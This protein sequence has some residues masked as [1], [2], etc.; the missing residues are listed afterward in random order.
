[1]ANDA[2]GLERIS[3]VVGY[4]L[5]KGNF[6]E[7]TPNLPQRIAILAEANTANQGSLDLTPKELTSAQAAGELYG[8][9]S[10]IYNIMRILRPNQGVGVG[11]IPTVVYPQAV[12][13]G[14]VANETEVTPVGTATKNGTHTLKI[15][16]RNG[17]DG[18]FYDINIVVG[19][20][21]A[22]VSTKIAD[23]IQAV[24]S[25]PCN[26]V[27]TA[28]EATLTAK[29]AG[30]T[31]EEMVVSVD[32]NDTDLGIT[33]VVAVTD[34]GL[35]TPSIAAA[36][37]LFGN[38]WNTVVINSYGTVSAAIDTLE[39]FNGIPDPLVP[40]GRYVGIV[41]KPFI[42]FTGSLADDDTTFT[43]AKKD[44]V[45]IALC[46][47][48]LSTGFTAEAAANMA[49]LYVRVAQDNPH[50]DVSGL[51]Y[52]DMPTP[53][54]I[55]SMETYENRDAFVKKGSST[56]ELSNGVYKVAD[57]VTT[58]HPDGELPPQ[59]RYV[60]NLNLDFNIRFGY[61]LLEEI[62]VVDHVIANDD[63]IVT[64]STVVKPKQWR[65]I[66]FRFAQDLSQR[67]L[68]V[69]PAFMQDS[70]TVD[71]STTNPDRLETFFRYKRTGFARISS[72]IA[73]A[74]FNFGTV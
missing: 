24:L 27:A 57:F 40:T 10:P 8:F 55:G 72:T 16:G 39:A 63:D 49:A 17:V 46:P 67:A 22:T 41:F 13:G 60:R 53:N 33:Y 61:F 65:Q 4:K 45:T 54:T 44:E 3:K 30:L 14:A 70:I 73:E 47:A 25:A 32:L 62:N 18:L 59:F 6:L 15:A 20:S 9:G 50:L 34:N 68:I 7:V 28:T 26:A 38:N 5:V 48:P 42:A 12:A 1:M 66:L 51:S 52:P 11:G 29:W 56:V 69:D 74:G 2:V 21:I 23:A 58:Y 36:L 37:A 43:D 71:I 31:S 19:D 64:A 35:G